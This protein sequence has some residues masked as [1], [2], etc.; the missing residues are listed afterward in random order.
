LI[1]ALVFSGAAVLAAAAHPQLVL[2][3]HPTIRFSENTFV[4][5]RMRWDYEHRG[6]A[7]S[8]PAGKDEWGFVR[9]R[10][11]LEGGI[12][13][14]FEFEIEADLEGDERW[15]DVYGE[16]TPSDA[17]HLRAG[18]FV[19]PFAYERTTALD[20]LDFAN[21]AMASSHLVPPRDQGVV[22]LGQLAGGR[23]AYDAGWFEDGDTLV[24]RLVARRFASGSWR[25]LEFGASTMYGG[26]GEGEVDP[27]R[28]QTALGHT[29]FRGDE[30]VSGQRVRLSAH[31]VYRRGPAA[32]KA[33]YLAVH[34]DVDGG[35]ADV[36][37]RGWYL[38]GAYV[39]TGEDEAAA[40]H[41][42]RPLFRGGIGSIEVA[43]RTE[44]LTFSA[45]GAP[46]SR[47]RAQT[48][49]VT[50]QP[51]RFFRVQ[52]NAVRD[53]LPSRRLWTRVLRFHLTI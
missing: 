35:G 7:S 45:S 25:G 16:L 2:E 12:G 38:T 40:H 5:G 47:A 29:F 52:W 41:P 20:I 42:R 30:I 3:E 46:R 8:L 11:S 24:A 18:K 32:L 9:R 44:E 14:I 36:G 22:A 37:G 28:G 51:I 15:K 1:P 6:P 33:E 17:F 19:V 27:L 53:V 50:W 13:R 43:A 34:D 23:I 21:R 49:G 31:G 4:L 26:V 39:L 48:F 10:F